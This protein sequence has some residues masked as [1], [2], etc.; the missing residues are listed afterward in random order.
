[1]PNI[2]IKIGAH[3]REILQNMSSKN[4]KHCNC[5]EK[6]NCPMNGACLK[7]SLFYYATISCKDK[8]YK[9]KLY[10]RSCKISFKKHYSNHK[11]P[12]N[13]PLYKHDTK[14]DTTENWNLK[15]KQLNQG[16]SWKIENA[17]TYALQR[18][19]FIRGP[20]QKLVE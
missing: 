2:K 1:M 15:T 14:H 12:F 9:P 10:K 4:A 7:E 6:E 20:R 17:V 3:H 18:S 8:N 5:Q 19:Q 13:V 11:K 16:I